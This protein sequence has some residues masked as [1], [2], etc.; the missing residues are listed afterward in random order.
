MSSRLAAASSK[1]P[2]DEL[3]GNVASTTPVAVAEHGSS[4]AMQPDVTLPVTGL[5]VDHKTRFKRF[6]RAGQSGI[7]S[8]NSR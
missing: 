4:T 3:S 5:V 6:R 1:E 7:N 8:D 2:S